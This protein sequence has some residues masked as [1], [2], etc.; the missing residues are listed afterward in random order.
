MII[1]AVSLTAYGMYSGH[2]ERAVF[3]YGWPEGIEV[4]GGGV[5]FIGTN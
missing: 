4:G 2:K 3:I 1:Y 5:R